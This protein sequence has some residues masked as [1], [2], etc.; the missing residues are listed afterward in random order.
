MIV[1]YVEGHEGHVMNEEFGKQ[2]WRTA[3]R[4]QCFSFVMP[5]SQILREFNQRP[6]SDAKLADL[7]RDADTLHYLFRI[8]LKVA[9]KDFGEKLKQVCLRPFVLVR[10]LQFMM[11]NEH[12]VFRRSKNVHLFRDRLEEVVH[13]KYPQTEAHL[14][15]ESREGAYGV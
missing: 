6:G 4:G 5:W 11:D 2:Q 13:A 15:P 9:G 7:P 12:E 1:Y 3:V 8:H 10:L 14:P